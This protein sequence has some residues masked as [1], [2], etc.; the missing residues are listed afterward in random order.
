MVSV[1]KY[2]EEEED[3]LGRWRRRKWQRRRRRK[4]KKRRNRCVC[5][6]VKSLRGARWVE[7]G[8]RL[9]YECT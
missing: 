8:T 3:G 5:F 2:V 1:R 4:K 9:Y 6:T 7:Q